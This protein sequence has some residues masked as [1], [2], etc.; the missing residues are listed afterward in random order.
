MKSNSKRKL[1][2]S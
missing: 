1:S 2:P